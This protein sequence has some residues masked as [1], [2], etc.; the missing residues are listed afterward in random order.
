MR[1]CN[2]ND[3]VQVKLTKRGLK[4]LDDLYETCGYIKYSEH[5]SDT[6]KFE[7]WELMNVFG[8]SL[9]NGSEPCFESNEIVFI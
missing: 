1:K 8:E 7:L 3:K 6:Y 9:F 5:T 2:V 4:V